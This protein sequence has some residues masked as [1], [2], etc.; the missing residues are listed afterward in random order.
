MIVPYMYLIPRHRKTLANMMV[1]TSRD[2]EV[3]LC[4]LSLRLPHHSLSVIFLGDRC[5]VM[6]QSAST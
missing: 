2:A 1:F 3:S 5:A 4:P 6:T